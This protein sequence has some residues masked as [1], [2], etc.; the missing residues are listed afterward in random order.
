MVILEAPLLSRRQ[1]DHADDKRDES[2]TQRRVKALAEYEIFDAQLSID[3]ICQ[4]ILCLLVKGCMPLE[5][6]ADMLQMDVVVMT[7]MYVLVPLG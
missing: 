6:M 5:Q 2:D 1:D 7:L 3:S 4:N